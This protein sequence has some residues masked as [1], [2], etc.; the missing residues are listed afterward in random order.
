[1]SL[2]FGTIGLFIVLVTMM[3]VTRNVDWYNE[4]AT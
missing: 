3:Y 2:L 1:M 4:Q